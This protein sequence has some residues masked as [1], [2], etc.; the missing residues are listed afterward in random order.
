MRK[1]TQDRLTSRRQQIKMID[2]LL[3]ELS[4]M[5]EHLTEDHLQKVVAFQR[6][7]DLHKL[8]EERV[9]ETDA[10]VIVGQLVLLARLAYHVNSSKR[11]IEAISDLIMNLSDKFGLDLKAIVKRYT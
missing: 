3:F 9:D 11:D 5:P 1:R 7:K 2:G 10:E 4:L 8:I 6:N